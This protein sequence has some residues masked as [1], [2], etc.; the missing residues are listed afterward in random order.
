MV[1]T[2]I[3]ILIALLLPAV[4]AAREAAR[5][6]QCSN[7]LKQLALGCLTHEQANGFFPTGGWSWSW[8]GDPDRGFDR[9]QPAGWTYNVL[10]Y[11]EQQA[12]H[13]LGA[14]MT[15]ANKKTAFTTRNATPIAT[16]YC[17]TRR[18]AA[19]YPEIPSYSY[20]YHNANRSTLCARTDYA[21]NTGTNFVGFDDVVSGDDPSAADAAGFAWPTY[22][23][24]GV[25]CKTNVIRI[26]EIPDGL[27]NTILVAE[28][29][30]CPDRYY[31]GQDD[32]DNNSP[33][34]GYDWDVVRWTSV[35]PRQDQE[36]SKD[37]YPFGSAHSNSFNAAFCDGS[38]QTLSYSIDCGD[39]ANGISGVFQHL[40]NRKDGV[41]IDAKMF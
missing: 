32:A 5:K 19:V 10:P 8:C 1:I 26:A 7:N 41:A 14:G 9:R 33:Y 2:I 38:V 35:A 11:I 3:G 40:G 36:G 12:M 23:C 22:D 37:S 28:K 21:G 27:S 6:M 29:Y 25:I 30:L 17:P 34:T 15:V 18:Q 4:Q 39:I 13:D 20:P 16:L 31:D 24:N